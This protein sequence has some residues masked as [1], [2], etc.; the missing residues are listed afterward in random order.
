MRERFGEVVI[1][2]D[3]PLEEFCPPTLSML[4]ASGNFESGSL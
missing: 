3:P 4:L 2:H 1:A